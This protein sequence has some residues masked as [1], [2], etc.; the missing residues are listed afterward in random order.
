MNTIAAY[1]LICVISFWI[2]YTVGWI[3]AHNIVA[4]E[5]IKLGSFYVGNQVFKCTEVSTK[6]HQ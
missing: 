6:E 3:K 4:T 1:I 5:C 2:G